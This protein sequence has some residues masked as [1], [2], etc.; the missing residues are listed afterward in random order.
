[1]NPCIEKLKTYLDEQPINAVYNDAE[2][3]LELLCYIYITESPI[4]NATIHYQYQQINSI[5]E[6]FTLEENNQIFNLTVDMCDTYI[7]QA[8]MDGIR[9]G[10]HLLTELSTFL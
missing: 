6:R 1:M 4:D 9:V 8:F 5:M 2:S 10:Y 7:R 3:L